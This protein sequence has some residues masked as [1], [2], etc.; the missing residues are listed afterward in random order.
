MRRW[1]QSSQRSTWPPNAAV[2]Q[3]SI[4]DMTFSWPRLTWPAW[5]T[6]QAGPRRRKMSATSTA[7]RDNGGASAG[8]LQQQVER[9]RHLAD[10]ADGDAGVERGRVELFVPEQDLDDP[11]IGLLLQQ[12]GGKAVPQRMNPDTLGDAGSCRCQADEPVQLAWAHVL[13]A[14]AG[15]QPGLTRTHPSLLAGDAP[16]FTQELKKVRRED[17][18]PILLALALLDPDEHPVTVDIGEPQRY[19]L[20]SPQA[21]GISQAEGR[22]MLDV[23]RRREKPSD[24]FRAKNNGQAARL[25]DRHD[26]VGKIAALQ[27]D[28]EEEPQRT[29]TGV[30]SEE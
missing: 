18:I 25:A 12:M 6:R 16:P 5:D 15:K 17:D 30:R 20:R 21:S 28:L 9:A 10:R 8:R 24:L 14:V 2:R 13:P 3:R 22:L 23:H 11:D 27:R 29:G 26:R 19:D 1:A 4:A 7:G